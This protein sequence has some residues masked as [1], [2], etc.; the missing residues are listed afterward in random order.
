MRHPVSIAGLVAAAV[1]LLPQTAL[2]AQ[3]LDGA[4]MS[5]L[6]ALP[7]I[8]ILLSIATGPLLYPH[9]WEHHYGKFAA[10]WAA[11]V[12]VPL[13]LSAGGQ[14]ATEALL[15]TILLEYAPFILLLFALYTIAGSIFL[16]GN[17]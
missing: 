11:C 15:H 5:M 13:F 17:L 10:F 4:S 3:G 16:E 9:L 2:A 6:W 7:F 14:G 1:L 12:I 8:G